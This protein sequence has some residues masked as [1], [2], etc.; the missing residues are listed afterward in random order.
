MVCAYVIRQENRSAWDDMLLDKNG[1]RFVKYSYSG[2]AC[3]VP[4]AATG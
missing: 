3:F 2:M 4:A 1:V